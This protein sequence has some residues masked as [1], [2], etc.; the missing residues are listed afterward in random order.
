MFWSDE[1]VLGYVGF[2][3]A[4]SAK[5]VAPDLSYV[6]KGRVL[7][8]AFTA[9]SNLNGVEISDRASILLESRSADCLHG[10]QNAAV[11][12]GYFIGRLRDDDPDLRAARELARGLPGEGDESSNV[13]AALNQLLFSQVI[14]ERFR[15]A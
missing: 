11:V 6:D 7:A 9:L 1:F 10:S 2:M 8:D 4:A 12:F 14:K 3:I 15:K 5:L 13:F